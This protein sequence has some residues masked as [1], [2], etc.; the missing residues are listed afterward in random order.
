MMHA[1]QEMTIVN[2]Q[3]LRE[4]IAAAKV[5]ARQQEQARKTYSQNR[6]LLCDLHDEEPELFAEQTR[7]KEKYDAVVERR[8]T[9]VERKDELEAKCQ[10]EREEVAALKLQLTQLNDS[11]HR[12][13]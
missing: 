8:G 12:P 10:R 7:L 13:A 9:R 1:L 6:E 4:E 2:T 3:V 11:P 5:L